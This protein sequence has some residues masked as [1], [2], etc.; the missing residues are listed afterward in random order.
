LSL[1]ALDVVVV[2]MLGV[3]PVRM[4]VDD[5]AVPVRVLVNQVGCQQQR[6]VGQDLVWSAF[7]DRPMLL[8]AE[9]DDAGGEQRREIELVRRDDERV[10][11]LVERCQEI[12]EVSTAAR[13]EVRRR[14]VEQD[15]VGLHDQ[16]RGQSDALLLPAAELERGTAGQMGEMQFFEHTLDR[17]AHA[18]GWPAELEW[19][20]GDVVEDGRREQLD[21]RFLE[22]QPDTLV[23]PVAEVRGRPQQ[24]S[25][26]GRRRRG[27]HWRVDTA[28]RGP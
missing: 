3:V 4:R 5:R 16:H 19:P 24:R 15:D 26:R 8:L 2:L 21:V 25:H 1:L 12:D 14:L 7:G 6:V 13:I 17:V 11:A 10:T 28:R 27:G 20:E 18:V 22:D 23:Q 9:H